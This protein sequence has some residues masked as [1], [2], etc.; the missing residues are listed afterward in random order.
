MI[1]RLKRDGEG[2]RDGVRGK[3]GLHADVMIKN[4]LFFCFEKEKFMLLYE[5][6]DFQDFLFLHFAD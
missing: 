1:M 4:V 6:S 2:G 5:F 3:N